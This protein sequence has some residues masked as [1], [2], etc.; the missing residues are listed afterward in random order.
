MRFWD[1]SAIIPLCLEEPRTSLLKKLAEDDGAIAAWWST[2]VECWS[3]FAR[4]RR[5]SLVSKAEEDQA[6]TVLNRLAGDWTEIEPGREVREQAGRALLL[7]PLR[8]ADS[9]Q[10]AAALV[11]ANGRGAGHE[12][13]CLDQRLREAAQS[14]GFRVLPPN[15]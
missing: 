5:E 12:F 2:P 14:E 8:A 11:W 15:E 3:A 1:A 6:R 4:L 9:L 13:V 10:L 7:H